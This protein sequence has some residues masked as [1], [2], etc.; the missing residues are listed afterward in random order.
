MHGIGKYRYV[1]RDVHNGFPYW[2]AVSSYD[3]GEGQYD[4]LERP[5]KMYGSYSQSFELIYPV[6]GS[7]RTLDHVRVVPNPFR[8]EAAWDLAETEFEYSGKR[9]C[10]QNLPQEATIRVYT[11]SGD[12][13]QVL[14]HNAA[15]EF[16]ETC[17]NLITRNDQEMVSGIYLY[18]V[19]SSIGSKTGKFAV[20]R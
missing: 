7:H 19:E 16:S 5:V 17:W 1:D 11:L 15:T 4:F 10:F 14:H 18:H 8:L 3:T 6:S 9:I 2:Y 13:V 20:I 12:L